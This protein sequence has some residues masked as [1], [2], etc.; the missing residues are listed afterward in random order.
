[1][2]RMKSNIYRKSTTWASGY[3]GSL[4]SL[5]MLYSY[6]GSEHKSP[7]AMERHEK[8]PSFALLKYAE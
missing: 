3:H 2:H 4:P 1:M 6:H 5:S 8:W 7:L